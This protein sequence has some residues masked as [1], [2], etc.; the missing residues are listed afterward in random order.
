MLRVRWP[1]RRL[2][3]DAFPKTHL[4]GNLVNNPLADSP[5]FTYPDIRTELGCFLKPYLVY[6]LRQDLQ[7]DAY[8]LRSP[9]RISLFI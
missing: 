9:E 6:L 7:S 8:F 5:V 4:S 2:L 3:E 1:V